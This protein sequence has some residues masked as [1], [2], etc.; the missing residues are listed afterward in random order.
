MNCGSIRLNLLLLAGILIICSLY[1]IPVIARFATFGSKQITFTGPLLSPQSQNPFITNK[2]N[3]EELDQELF[4]D[5]L[6]STTLYTNRGD[7]LQVSIL[8]HFF[9]FFFD[10]SFG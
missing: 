8:I 4:D 7:I 10:Q 1:I 3:L 5:I 9:D 2:K 6:P